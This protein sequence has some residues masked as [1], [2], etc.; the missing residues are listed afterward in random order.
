MKDVIYM[1][2]HFKNNDILE[3]MQS[4]YNLSSGVQL[5]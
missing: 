3:L 4:D 1:Q 2:L 5:D